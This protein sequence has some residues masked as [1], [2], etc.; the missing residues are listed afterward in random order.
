MGLL[1][2]TKAKGERKKAKET[3]GA[4]S[5]FLSPFSFLLF[6]AGEP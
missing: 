1:H 5:F 6:T 4:G 2:I 3:I